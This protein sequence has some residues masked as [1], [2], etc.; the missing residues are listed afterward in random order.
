MQNIHINTNDDSIFD[1]KINF[2]KDGN[3]INTLMKDIFNQY[4]FENSSEIGLEKENM[5]Y[6]SKINN[7]SFL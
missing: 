7:N 5:I 6:L 1:I 3:D 4:I 2:N